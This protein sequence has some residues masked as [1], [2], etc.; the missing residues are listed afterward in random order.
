LDEKR[1]MYKKRGKNGLMLIDGKKRKK[2]KIF[3]SVSWDSKPHKNK[4]VGIRDFNI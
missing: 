2:R 1:E 4:M 3:A